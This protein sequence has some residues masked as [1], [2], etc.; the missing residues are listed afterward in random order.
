[1]NPGAEGTHPRVFLKIPFFT[2]KHFRYQPNLTCNRGIRLLAKSCFL[3]SCETRGSSTVRAAATVAWWNF[4]H[5]MPKVFDFTSWT[6]GRTLAMGCH[7]L[8]PWSLTFVSNGMPRACPVVPHA[9]L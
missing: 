6:L 4:L 1:M 2:S 8:V 3:E 7:R 9:R 5:V